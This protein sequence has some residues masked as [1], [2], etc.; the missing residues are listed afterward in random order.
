MRFILF[1]VKRQIQ[2][3]VS[4]FGKQ[5]VPAGEQTCEGFKNMTVTIHRFKTTCGS[6]VAIKLC[7]LGSWAHNLSQKTLTN[8]Q[9]VL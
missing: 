7:L 4:R 6:L 3:C 8:H 2:T 1:F 9:L 5:H